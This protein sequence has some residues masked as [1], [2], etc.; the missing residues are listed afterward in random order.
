MPQS[1]SHSLQAPPEE[2][3]MQ[4]RRGRGHP[5]VDRV[6]QR[7]SSAPQSPGSRH[8][9][10]PRAPSPKAL[11]HL[12]PTRTR[13]PKTHLL[14]DHDT[15]TSQRRRSRSDARKQAEAAFSSERPAGNPDCLAEGTEGDS[16]TGRHALAE[17]SKSLPETGHGQPA[18]KVTG[19]HA[20]LSAGP[21]A[22]GTASPSWARPQP[23]AL[24]GEHPEI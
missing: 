15:R 3:N 11:D 7:G 14:Q 16:M 22:A 2:D 23:S 21:G 5:R 13:T 20:L 6:P 8:H 17:K 9:M 18:D 4:S 19:L 10:L 24:R 12:L 1:Q